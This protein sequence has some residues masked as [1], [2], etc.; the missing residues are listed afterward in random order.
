MY[1]TDGREVDKFD[2][3]MVEE[4]V[5]EKPKQKQN[6]FDDGDFVGARIG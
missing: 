2:P 6:R 5:K 4:R 3:F 1:T